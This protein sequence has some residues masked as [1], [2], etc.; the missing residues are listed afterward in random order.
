MSF[1]WG[2]GTDMMKSYQSNRKQINPHKSLKDIQKSS[3]G[4]AVTGRGLRDK[5]VSP[6]KMQEIRDRLAL[7]RSIENKRRA[8]VIFL[9]AALVITGLLLFLL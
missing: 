9:F 2:P 6:E 8:F 3:P 1:G 7:E 5:E 4:S